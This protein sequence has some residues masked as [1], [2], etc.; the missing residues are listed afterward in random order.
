MES[1][2]GPHEVLDFSGIPKRAPRRVGLETDF[3]ISLYIPVSQDLIVMACLRSAMARTMSGK[4]SGAFACKN[5]LISRAK[6]KIWA[7]IYCLFHR[8]LCHLVLINV[9]FLGG[10]KT[11]HGFQGKSQNE[12]AQT[13]NGLYHRLLWTFH[14]L[15]LYHPGY[16]QQH[17]VRQA[18]PGINDSL[19]V[20]WYPVTKPVSRTHTA[21]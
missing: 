14:A 12:C 6:V 9:L 8:K 10:L 1:Q 19:T 7:I 17:G 21:R 2:R 4:Q 18:I 13:T 5:G 11:L 3:L 20:L 15:C 16:G